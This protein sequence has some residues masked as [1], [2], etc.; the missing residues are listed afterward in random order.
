MENRQ[1]CTVGA[2][3]EELVRVPARCERLR[4]RLAVADDAGDEQVG[5]IERGTIGVRQRIP[6]LAALVNRPGRLRR[7]VA[8]NAARERELL[9][10]PLHPA[11]VL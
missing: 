10:Q 6:E 8:R 4:L 7:H 2:R 5:V 1:H 3:I 11:L 9:E